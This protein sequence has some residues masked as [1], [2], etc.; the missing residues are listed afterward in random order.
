MAI[1][2]VTGRVAFCKASPRKHFSANSLLALQEAVQ[3]RP[4]A[5]LRSPLA[6]GRR[7]RSHRQFPVEVLGDLRLGLSRLPP[8]KLVEALELGTQPCGMP[9]R[10]R[11][12]APGGR[13][14][15][16]C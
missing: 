13:D 3:L 1:Q 7:Q 15:F 5:D 16:G 9:P 12:E 14:R 6:S 10:A 4:P 11:G 8:Q 2:Y